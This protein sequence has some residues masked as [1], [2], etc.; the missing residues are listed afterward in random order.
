MDL[1]FLFNNKIALIG[2]VA[3]VAH[4]EFGNPCWKRFRRGDNS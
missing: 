3:E 2:E 4:D 1:A